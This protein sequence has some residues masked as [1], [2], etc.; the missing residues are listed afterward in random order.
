MAAGEGVLQH[1]PHLLQHEL[2][3]GVGRGRAGP[4]P[5]AAP[6]RGAGLATLRILLDPHH[7]PLHQLHRHP[8]GGGGA[9]GLVT[10]LGLVCR[11]PGPCGG[12]HPLS[13]GPLF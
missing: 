10:P 12:L 2:G 4:D 11:H 6:A 7:L 9:G 1:L 3:P 5:G 13:T 8:G